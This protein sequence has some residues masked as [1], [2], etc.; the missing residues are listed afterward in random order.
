[1]IPVLRILRSP[2]VAGGQK[3]IWGKLYGFLGKAGDCTGEIG[4]SYFL[5]NNGN[6]DFRDGV[7]PLSVQKCFLSAVYVFHKMELWLI[8]WMRGAV[9]I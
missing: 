1:M 2:V 4:I 3:A 6:N 8:S 7:A 5:L 9:R